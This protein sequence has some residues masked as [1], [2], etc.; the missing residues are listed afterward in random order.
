[1]A[2]AADGKVAT[3]NLDMP[4]SFTPETASTVTLSLYSGFTEF[5]AVYPQYELIASGRGLDALSPAPGQQTLT[6]SIPADLLHAGANEIGVRIRYPSGAQKKLETHIQKAVATWTQP[7]PAPEMAAEPFTTDVLGL[8]PQVLVYGGAT[9]TSPSALL[10]YGGPGEPA[11]FR[12]VTAAAGG[13][14]TFSLP[15]SQAGPYWLVDPAT[16]AKPHIAA[17]RRLELFDRKLRGDYVAI[18]HASLAS[19]LE[20][21][22]ERRR[23]QGHTVAVADVDEIFDHFSFGL[24]EAGAIKAFLTWAYYEWPAPHIESVVL[25][26]EAS[27][28]RREPGGLPAGGNL[29]MLPV[30]GS[31]RSD[32]PRGDQP[33]TTICG[34]DQYSDIALGRIS[35][36][37]PEELKAVIAKI[38]S[39]EDSPPDYRLL[40]TMFVYDDNEEFPQVAADVIANGME[41]SSDVTRLEQ[42]AFPYELNLRVNGR[43][44]SRL[45]TQALIDAFNDGRGIINYFGHGGPNL[46]SHERLLHL[47]DLKLLHNGNLLPFVT[48]SSCDNAWIDYPIPPVQTSMGELFV[49]QRN[50]GAIGVFAPV[51]GA[52]PYEHK[53]L[54]TRLMEAIWRR[55]ITRL[56]DAT[57]FARNFYF[58]DTNSASLPEQYVLIGDPVTSLK[59]PGNIGNLGATPAAILP[60]RSARLNVQIPPVAKTESKAVVSLKSLPDLREITSLTCPIS[61]NGGH[62]ELETGALPAGNYAVSAVSANGLAASDTRIVVSEPRLVLSDAAASATLITD[63]GSSLP[64]AIRM[65]NPG[66]MPVLGA[67]VRG[68]FYGEDDR[69]EPVFRQFLRDA[70]NLLPGESR[71]LKFPWFTNLGDRLS[72][73]TDSGSE[74]RIDKGFF[75]RSMEPGDWMAIPE[76]TIRFA[77]NPPTEFESPR[78]AFDV[79]NIGARPVSAADV[80]LV[81]NG[82]EVSEKFP[83][84]A[85]QP[86]AS[87]TVTATSR[88][89]FPVGPTSIT[90][91]VTS[92]DTSTSEG[93]P[94]VICDVPYRFN[95]LAGPDLRFVPGSARADQSQGTGVARQTVFARASLQN[96]GE[97][98]ARNVAISLVVGDPERGTEGGTINET[99]VVSI[100]EIKPGETVPVLFR[101]ENSS[102]PGE[103]QIWLV[104]NRNAPNTT[105]LAGANRI[106]IPKFTLK[107]LSNFSISRFDVSPV[108]GPAGTSLTLHISA[109]NDGD[110]PRSGI[111]LEYGLRNSLTEKSDSVTTTIALIPANSDASISATIAASGGY[112]QVFATINSNKDSDEIDPGDNTA[113]MEFTPVVSAAALR[114]TAGG[115]SFDPLFQSVAARNFELL[116]G[117][118]LRVLDQFTSATGLIPVQPDLVTEGNITS[119]PADNVNYELNKWKVLPWRLAIGPSEKPGDVRIRIPAPGLPEGAPVELNALM[120]VGGSQNGQPTGAFDITLA[121]DVTSRGIDYSAMGTPPSERKLSLGTFRVGQ[122]ALDFKISPRYGKALLIK[123]FELVPDVAYIETPAIILPESLR[124]REFSMSAVLDSDSTD[125][126]HLAVELGDIKADGHLAVASTLEGQTLGLSGRLTAPLLRVR[127]TVLGRPAKSLAIRDLQL[128]VG[129]Q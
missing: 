17:A 20:P 127:V 81:W 115:F 12:Q 15:S 50:G 29:D 4:A 35:V 41:P 31:P 79:W 78:L 110:L 93:R 6:F 87:R 61:R 76:T 119:S 126:V 1:M 51:S 52:S 125:P 90:I 106:E 10:V 48:C 69:A 109:R 71:I 105:K 45:G 34:G 68:V 33:Y 60:D 77:P 98:V 73:A 43:Q 92:R 66:A 28:H 117:P 83:I 111:E 70:V 118:A 46:W 30:N 88:R 74:S 32:A 38:V 8:L 121:D 86:N 49:K 85:L 108:G 63:D 58:L 21:L 24:R 22:L 14:A 23:K 107:R 95:V 25:V 89:A 64:M 103:P 56:G 54:M 18:T 72:V 55:G 11:A 7:L 26:G 97:S 39:Y 3:F 9:A 5:P 120:E 44:R 123:A 113:F 99:N 129:A 102:Q 104:A 59:I 65:F 19:A 96:L 114:R 53:G 82:E 13:G 116:P 16:A 42:S 27:A 80:C 100:P 75:I 128:K 122:G 40:R 62:A 36:S 94:M 112:D 84:P 124:G 101:W 57:M 2:T 37:K 67:S 91:R 47:S